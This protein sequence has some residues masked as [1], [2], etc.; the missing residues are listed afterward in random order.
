M[1]TFFLLACQPHTHLSWNLVNVQGHLPNL[2]FSMIDD[3][4]NRLSEKVVANKVVILYFGF[5]HCP[6]VCPISLAKL[7]QVINRLGPLA[8]D[9]KIIF[10]TV[11]PQRDQPKA[12]HAYIKAFDENSIIGLTGTVKEVEKIAKRYRVAFERSRAGKNGDYQVTHSSAIYF[13]DKQGRARLIGTQKDEV[14]AI[15]ND[16]QQLLIKID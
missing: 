3:L 13:F 10:V 1:L 5:T 6:D 2:R 12:L 9:V 11:D 16:L 8:Q 4:G 15:Y 14:A 7:V